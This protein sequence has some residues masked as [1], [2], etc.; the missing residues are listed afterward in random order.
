MDVTWFFD[1]SVCDMR[2]RVGVRWS[3]WIYWMGDLND[4]FIFPRIS[5][6]EGFQ[7]D[8]LFISSNANG[9]ISVK[10]FSVAL[11]EH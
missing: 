7:S 4:S 11:G 8:N 10:I 1:Y 9:R 3:D 6:K 5:F 2:L